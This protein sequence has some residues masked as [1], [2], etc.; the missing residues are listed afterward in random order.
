MSSV[1]T[2]SESITTLLLSPACN[3]RATTGA[4]FNR[5]T[6]ERQFLVTLRGLAA[7]IA[8]SIRRYDETIVLDVRYIRYVSIPLCKAISTLHVSHVVKSG[9][10]SREWIVAKFNI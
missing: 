2:S 4:T 5:I 9:S 3:P 1:P 8:R 7:G 6:R 10:L